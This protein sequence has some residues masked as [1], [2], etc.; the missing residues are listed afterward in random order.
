MSR[1]YLVVHGANLELLGRREPE[2]YGTVTLAEMSPPR[3]VIVGAVV[4]GD[5]VFVPSG[6]DRLEVGDV[7]IL[8]VQEEHLPTIHLLF[9]GKEPA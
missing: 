7:V 6:P 1:H 9:P 2:L 3:G 4:R 8:F 5:K